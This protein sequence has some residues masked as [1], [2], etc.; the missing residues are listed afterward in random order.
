VDVTITT[1]NKAMDAYASLGMKAELPISIANALDQI[2][3]T[4]HH[5]AADDDDYVPGE[6]D[7][8]S[9]S[10]SEAADGSDDTLVDS[11][12]H[13]APKSTPPTSPTLAHCDV[14]ELHSS[15]PPRACAS[16]SPDTFARPSPSPA[17]VRS[18]M[19]RGVYYSPTSPLPAPVRAPP[20]PQPYSPK[21]SPPAPPACSIEDEDELAASQLQAEMEED[22]AALGRKRKYAAVAEHHD[23]PEYDGAP[24]HDAASGSGGAGDPAGKRRKLLAGLLE[25]VGEC[26]AV[27]SWTAEEQREAGEL[28]FRLQAAVRR[29]VPRPQEG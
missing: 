28:A 5:A 12:E 25:L 20:S 1:W 24:C 14:V 19:S 16:P 17:R 7:A 22:E 21:Y 11:I 4:V 9:D 13:D 26:E 3:E 29:W 10:S 15:P 6:A 18:S 23:V 8:A 27:A 2:N